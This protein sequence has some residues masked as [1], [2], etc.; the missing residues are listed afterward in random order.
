M[1]F[2]EDM[3]EEMAA[4]DTHLLEDVVRFYAVL[5]KIYCACEA[6]SGETF[7]GLRV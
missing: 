7:A 6:V 2:F 5:Q 1:V 4:L 3:R